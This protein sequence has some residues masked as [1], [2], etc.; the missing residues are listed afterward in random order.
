MN[1]MDSNSSP[2]AGGA[3]LP[4]Q[5]P[6]AVRG[7]GYVP[8]SSLS[9]NPPGVSSSR[10][11]TA[12]NNRG[13]NVRIPY[14]RVAFPS[15]QFSKNGEGGATEENIK[16]HTLHSGEIAWIHRATSDKTFMTSKRNRNGV[17][18]PVELRSMRQ[19]MQ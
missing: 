7:E 18:R 11:A 4:S 13:S 15:Q 14:A 1:R 16:M 2:Y 9:E 10:T 6:L 12:R 5:N 8:F 17:F 3:L 19:M